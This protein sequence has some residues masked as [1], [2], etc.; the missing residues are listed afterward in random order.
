[1]EGTAQTP[2]VRQELGERVR[3]VA[4]REITFDGEGF[5]WDPHQWS[6]DVAM[7]L[8]EEAGLKDLGE[9]HWAILRFLRDYYFQNGRSPLNRQIKE[10]T[11]ISLMEMEALFP[12][13]IKY[14][15]RRLAGLPNPRNCM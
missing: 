5:F 9:A 3:H 8:A 15:A 10:G 2:P 1:M 11:G 13:G 12:G 14:G 4:G 7:A 6:D